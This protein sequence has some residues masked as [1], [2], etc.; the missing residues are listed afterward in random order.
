PDCFQKLRP[1]ACRA[2]ASNSNDLNLDRPAT[3][4]DASR[5]NASLRAIPRCGHSSPQAPPDCRS[6][7]LPCQAIEAGG[8]RGVALLP[9]LPTLDLSKGVGG[10]PPRLGSSR[11]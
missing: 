7:T 6:R 4:V 2:P 11:R 5:R 10:G 3:K 8:P 9:W 1:P